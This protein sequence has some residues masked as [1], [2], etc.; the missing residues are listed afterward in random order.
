MTDQTPV[1]PQGVSAAAFDSA[2][3]RLRGLLGAETC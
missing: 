3:G 1:L 2:L